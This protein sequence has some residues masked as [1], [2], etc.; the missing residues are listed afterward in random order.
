MEL[1]H[2]R[3]VTSV[4]FSID[5]MRI[6]SG[7]WDR[8]VRVW[9]TKTGEQL[10]ELQGHTGWVN[11]VSFSSDGNRIVSGSDDKSVRVWD[12]KTGKRLMKLRGTLS[13]RSVSFSSD[14][15]RIVAAG[16][17]VWVWDARTGELLRELQDKL[18]NNG[19]VTAVSF[20][21]DVDRIVTGSLDDSVRIWEVKTGEL[22]REL[23]GHINS[24]TS[25]TFSSDDSRIV[26][27]SS[28]ESI[29]VWSNLDLDPS[30][31]I[32]EDGWI[33]SYV[34]RLV[35]VPSTI[36]NILLTLHNT[37]IISRNGSATISFDECKLGS[38]W[39]HCYTP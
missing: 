3:N 25:V 33:V 29:R 2:I 7:S 13:V 12:A 8:S 39:Y 11:S 28:D 16:R 4:S 20:S 6:V 1:Q 18:D 15:S 31:A 35:W 23:R 34:D 37:L 36:R 24:V 17:S 10:R 5:G 30:W 14:G 38:S 9:D 22:L 19:Y 26:S 32:D 21:N 27:G